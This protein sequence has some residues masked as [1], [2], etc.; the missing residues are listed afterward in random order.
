MQV[1]DLNTV[2]HSQLT[3]QSGGLA[4]GQGSAACTWLAAVRVGSSLAFWASR[5]YMYHSALSFPACIKNPSQYFHIFTCLS[6]PYLYFYLDF[7]SHAS[8]LSPLEVTLTGLFFSHGLELA[9]LCKTNTFTTFLP[10]HLSCAFCQQR[11][12]ASILLLDFFFFCA[13]IGLFIIEF[14]KPSIFLHWAYFV[15]YKVV[16]RLW[17][18]G[19]YN[20]ADK[21]CIWEH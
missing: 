6:L 14:F 17:H 15:S 4:S 20:A 2:Q 13:K 8:I 3:F 5:Y 18:L 7:F 1:K 9:D 19:I 12:A 11:K 21:T 10:I 16:I